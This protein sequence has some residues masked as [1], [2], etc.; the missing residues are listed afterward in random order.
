MPPIPLLFAAAAPESDHREKLLSHADS[1]Y[2]MAHVLT[3]DATAA[4]ELVEAVYRR[5]SEETPPEGMDEKLWLLALLRQERTPS[6]GEG[7]E[8]RPL[9]A[10][11]GDFRRKLALRAVQREMPAAFVSLPAHSR[12]LLVLVH[13]ERHGAHELTYITGESLDVLAERLRRAEDDLRM[14]VERALTPNEVELLELIPDDWLRAALN[15][16]IANDLPVMPPTVRTDL[17]PTPPGPAPVRAPTRPASRTSLGQRLR[18]S[19]TALFIIFCAGLFSY[20]AARILDRPLVTDALELSVN[21]ASGMNLDVSSSDADEVERFLLERLDWRLVVPEIE[22]ATLLGVQ[23]REISSGIRVPALYY[24]DSQSDGPITL[25]AFNYALLDRS[26]DHVEF[27]AATLS[28]IEEAGHYELHD[29]GRQ[30]L[31]VWRHRNNIFVAVT[32]GTA[33]A[34]Q[35]RV[36]PAS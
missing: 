29:L 19:A 24:E 17:E 15:D 35:D 27:E 7:R 10:A 32:R 20:G 22:D 12:E 16:M 26:S 6:H 11:A 2:A 13:I 4:A 28:Q 34:L 33:E 30:H 9:R 1:I 18:R 25:V 8:A 23:I 31:L 14:L 5:A 36:Y 3:L 21:A